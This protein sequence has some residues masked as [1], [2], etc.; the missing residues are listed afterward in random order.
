MR[1]SHDLGLDASRGS[2]PAV[3]ELLV[4]HLPSL[5]SYVRLKAG[6]LVRAREAESDIVQSVCREVLGRQGDFRYGG[7]A[8]FRHWLFTTA[9]RK[10][11]D[12]RKLHTADKR[13]LR[14]EDA[15][16]GDLDARVDQLA[17]YASPSGVAI[18]HE[19]L[20]RVAAA[21]DALG[22]DYREVILLSRVVGLSRADIAREMDRTEASIRNLLHRAL[23]ELSRRLDD[24]GDAVTG[25]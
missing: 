14:R 25:T 3:D 21:F 23:A 19:E 9:L 6:R 2:E 7:E 15:G 4:R 18:G 20:E 17:A 16:A 24:S 12:K 11:L 1:S 10:I 22:D 8:G 5:R 13:D